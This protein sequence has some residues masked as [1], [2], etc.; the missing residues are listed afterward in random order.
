MLKKDLQTEA[1]KSRQKSES[2][3]RNEEHWKWNNER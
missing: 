3:Q 1:D 2:S